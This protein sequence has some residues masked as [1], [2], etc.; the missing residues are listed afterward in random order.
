M[1]EHDQYLD[2]QP[3]S[4]AEFHRVCAASPEMR[5]AK[6]KIILEAMGGLK[7]GETPNGG[8]QQCKATL[9]DIFVPSTNNGPKE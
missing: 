9:S 4:L 5:E 1:R 3:V 2:L 6:D 8:G 7:K